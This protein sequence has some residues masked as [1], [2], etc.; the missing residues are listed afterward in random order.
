M[1]F[2]YIKMAGTNLKSYKRCLPALSP[3]TP[4]GE[5][6]LSLSFLLVLLRIVELG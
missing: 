5:A 2:P 1:M 6:P 3:H 4:L